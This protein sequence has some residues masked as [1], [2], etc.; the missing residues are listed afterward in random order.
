M[1]KFMEI[2]ETKI[3]PPMAKLA[4]QRH[5]KAIRN[6]IIITMPLIIVG[7]LFLIL[8]NVPIETAA[9][10][11]KEFIAPYFSKL[12]VPFRLTVGLTALYASFG[13]GAALGR[14]Y[15]LDQVTSAVLATLGFLCTTIPV[16]ISGAFVGAA[17]DAGVVAGVSQAGNAINLAGG[18]YLMLS[19]LGS[20]G[21]FGAIV[22]SLI[23]VEIYNFCK[24]RNLTIKMP[25]GVPSSVANSFAVLVPAL[26]VVLLFWTIRV[27]F[28]F[29]INMA[30]TQLLSPISSFVSGNNIFGVYVIAILITLFWSAGLHGVSLVGA[31]ARPFWEVAIT[32]NMDAFAAGAAIPNMY[33]EQF[34]QWF[35]WIG[36]SGATIGLAILMAFFAKSQYLKQLGRVSFVPALF[37]IN[38]PIIFGAPIVMNPI[39]IIPFILAPLVMIT[40]AAVAMN[41]GLVGPM[42]ARAPWTLP[43]PL[44]AAMSVE[45][46][47]LF[48]A[49]LCL[50]N[51]AIAVAVYYPFFKAYD[52][53]M[54]AQET[55]EELEIA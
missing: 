25:E 54:A 16:N 46:G 34:F 6:G 19:T 7:S 35:V 3:M 20:A 13:I 17:T 43:G 15:K 21:L 33:T 31:V 28:E 38:E 40:T 39:L 12:V 14:I 55:G 4:E 47:H 37:N 29:D 53:Q 10:S 9:F 27:V 11:W 32:E 18:D 51:I 2:L 48:A 5:L 49:L 50:V 24:K 36:G 42:V 30:I 52:K 8:L 23:S 44:G 22:A 41:I 26:L 45:S 1:N